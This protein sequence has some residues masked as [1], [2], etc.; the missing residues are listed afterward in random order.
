MHNYNNSFDN[1]PY[2]LPPEVWQIAKEIEAALRKSIEHSEG[3]VLV[4]R[5]VRFPQRQCF[6]CLFHVR[7]KQRS[8]SRQ[9]ARDLA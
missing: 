2:S 3:G 5:Q 8:K 1:G 7:G 6:F 4:H 9:H